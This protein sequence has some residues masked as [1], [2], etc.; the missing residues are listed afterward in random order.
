MG[1]TRKKQEATKLD[2]KPAGRITHDSRGNAVW[3]RASGDSTSTMLKR[4]EIPGLSVEGEETAPPRSA[5]QKS[6]ASKP[7]SPPPDVGGGYNPYDQGKAVKKP[8]KPKGPIGRR[9][10]I[11]SSDK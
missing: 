3:G 6:A 5:P 4:L 1:D 8:T 9:R 7:A 2:D 10:P 11:I